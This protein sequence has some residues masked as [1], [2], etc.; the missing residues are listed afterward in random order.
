M[1]HTSDSVP[2]ILFD[3]T[4]DRAGEKAKNIDPSGYNE[5][6]ALA[7]GLVLEK[8]Y[9]LMDRLIRGGNGKT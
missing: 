1:T 7:T 9:T 3:S 2:F 8:G 5:Q 6:S 4:A